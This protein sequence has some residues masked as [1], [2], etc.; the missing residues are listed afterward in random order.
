VAVDY[1]L[2]RASN[3]STTSLRPSFSFI[4]LLIIQSK[5]QLNLVRVRT[6][7]F[8][9]PFAEIDHA[10]LPLPLMLFLDFRHCLIE[11][12]RLASLTNQTGY[13]T[14]DDEPLARKVTSRI[15]MCPRNYE[16]TTQEIKSAPKK[17]LT[18][19][20]LRSLPLMQASQILISEV[21]LLIPLVLF[22][23]A[24]LWRQITRAL[25]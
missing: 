5:S 14:D 4:W 1:H 18:V 19:I 9:N 24:N 15:S 25:R 10:W 6:I 12:P 16:R 7:F 23:V 21:A 17:P 22:L 8:A 2:P 11:V 3:S 20:P 13:A